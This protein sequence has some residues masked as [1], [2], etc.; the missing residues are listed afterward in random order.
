MGLI[1]RSQGLPSVMGMHFG[2]V[3]AA[4]AGTGNCDECV[5]PVVNFE[6]RGCYLLGI[7]RLIDTQQNFVVFEASIDVSSP[8]ETAK[9]FVVRA[10]RY[11]LRDVELILVIGLAGICRGIDQFASLSVVADRQHGIHGAL[12]KKPRRD[13]VRRGR[14]EFLEDRERI[15]RIF[16][17]YVR[18]RQDGRIGL[19][20]FPG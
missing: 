15:V 19:R 2:G 16:E 9:F 8:L 13:I 1:V 18:G 3:V 4:Q 12:P 17:V 6:K 5:R 14:F 10:G 20:A 7:L 11:G